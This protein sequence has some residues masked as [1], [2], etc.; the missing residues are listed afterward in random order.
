M[1]TPYAL[2]VRRVRT[3]ED[4]K[5]LGREWRED[6]LGVEFV[7]ELEV[8][9]QEVQDVCGVA[10]KYLS[11]S[12]NEDFRAALT[13]AVINLAYYASTDIGESFR[14]QVLGRLGYD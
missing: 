13:V 2:M 3:L 10:G 1:S 5:N 8:T 7:G 11:H 4:L 14:W 6:F 12:W 9:E